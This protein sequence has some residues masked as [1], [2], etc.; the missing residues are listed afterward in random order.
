MI[1]KTLISKLRCVWLGLQ[2]ISA[3]KWISRARLEDPWAKWIHLHTR[4][5]SLRFF[6]KN[7]KIIGADSLV[8]QHTA[9]L[10]FSCPKFKSRL[11]DLSWSH[12]LLSL[13]L[14]FLSSLHCPIKLKSQNHLSEN[15]KI[16]KIRCVPICILVQYSCSFCSH[17]KNSSKCN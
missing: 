5:I 2:L 16:S 12:P 17:T 15:N 11:A 13:P 6:F 7:V 1:L 10:C 9:P 14:S 3:G 4:R 8:R